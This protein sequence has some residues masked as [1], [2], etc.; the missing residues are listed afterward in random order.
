MPDA[1]PDEEK[2]RRLAVLNDRQRAIQIARNEFF[3]GETFEL[4]VDSHHSAR[5]QWSGRSSHNRIVNFTSLSENLLG[6]Y[7]RVK[8]TRSGPNS[9]V[10][11]H[12]L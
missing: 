5:N 2:A 10:G 11:E 6:Q 12:L 9:L 4:L 7:V 3:V 8:V 1:I